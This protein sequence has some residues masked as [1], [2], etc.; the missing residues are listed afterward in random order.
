MGDSLSH[1]DDLLVTSIAVFDGISQ[2]KL[3]ISLAAL[4]CSACRDFIWSKLLQF[5]QMVIP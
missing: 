4:Q 2:G 1:L 5:P 3:Q